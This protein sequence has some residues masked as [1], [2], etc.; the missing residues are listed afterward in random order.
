MKMEADCIGFQQTCF[1]H[2]SVFLLSAKTGQQTRPKSLW[3][4]MFLV[5]FTQGLLL[6][7]PGNSGIPGA[8]AID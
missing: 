2:P 7:Y 8:G 1:T 4:L 3:L 5:P 6:Q